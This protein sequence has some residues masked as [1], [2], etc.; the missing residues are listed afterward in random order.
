[1]INIEFDERSVFTYDSI[2]LKVHAW[3]HRDGKWEGPVIGQVGS[4]KFADRWQVYHFMEML[5]F[6]LEKLKDEN[7]IQ[8]VEQEC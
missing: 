3:D 8:E 6:M 2:N 5:E 1:M 7:K 4:I